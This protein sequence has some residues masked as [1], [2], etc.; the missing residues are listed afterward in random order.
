VHQWLTLVILA[1]QETE[2]QR[3]MVQ[4]QSGQDPIWKYL[5]QKR[6]YRVVQVIEHLPSQCEAL[7]S[8]PSTTKKSK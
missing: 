7:S 4:G 5:K 6:V 2:I 1:T 3:I 8:S